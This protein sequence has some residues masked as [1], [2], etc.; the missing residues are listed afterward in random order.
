MNMLETLK[1][2]EYKWRVVEG[3]IESCLKSS[4]RNTRSR[5]SHLQRKKKWKKTNMMMKEEKMMITH[6]FK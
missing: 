4:R 1:G 6:E 5:F 3:R 2:G